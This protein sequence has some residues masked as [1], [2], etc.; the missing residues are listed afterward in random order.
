MYLAHS[1]FL[2]SHSLSPSSS[3]NCPSSSLLQLF[4]SLLSSHSS[5]S[6]SHSLFSPSHLSLPPS[7]SSL[8]HSPPYTHPQ[9]SHT[10]ADRRISNQ[11]SSTSPH[12]TSHSAHHQPTALTGTQ[13]MHECTSRKERGFRTTKELA[14]SD[15]EW[16]QLTLDYIHMHSI[17]VCTHYYNRLLPNMLN[18]S[19]CMYVCMYTLASERGVVTWYT[20]NT[21]LEHTGWCCPRGSLLQYMQG[22]FNYTQNC[23]HSLYVR[24]K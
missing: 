17:H 9:Y 23:T 14:A 4:I 7:H 13:Y 12:Q 18:G 6:L 1:I 24:L 2:H 3:L 15:A 8:S 10:L 20:R 21:L 5:L 11:A 22:P 19:A 16:T